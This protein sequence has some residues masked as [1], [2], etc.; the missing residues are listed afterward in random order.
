MLNLS[1]M[2]DKKGLPAAEFDAVLGA[3]VD[4]QVSVELAELQKLAQ[5][6]EKESKP[7]TPKATKKVDEKDAEE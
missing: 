5:K 3:L 6:Q 7:K 4:A 1:E 2:N